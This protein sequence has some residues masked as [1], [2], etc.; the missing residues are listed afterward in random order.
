M[1]LRPAVGRLGALAA[2][3][4]RPRAAVMILAAMG[5]LT[6]AKLALLAYGSG[7][8]PPPRPIVAA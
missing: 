1:I 8:T 4:A 6:S 2:A 5:L 7:A 3:R